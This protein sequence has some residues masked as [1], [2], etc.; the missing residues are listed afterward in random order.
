MS[1]DKMRHP[2]RILIAVV[3]AAAS[4]GWAVGALRWTDVF[5]IEDTFEASSR[6]RSTMR[7]DE[8]LIGKG[9]LWVVGGESIVRRYGI[10]RTP[11]QRLFVRIAAYNDPLI[12][13]EAALVFRSEDTLLDRSWL[14]GRRIEITDWVNTGLTEFELRVRS[15]HP[16]GSDPRPA[17]KAFGFERFGPSPPLHLA[18]FVFFFGACTFFWFLILVFVVPSAAGAFAADHRD[19]MRTHRRAWA[20]GLL[21]CISALAWLANHGAWA[22][23]KDY[24]DR[25]AI[26]NGATMLES[27]YAAEKLY[28]RSRVRPAFPALIQPLLVAFPHR[29]E[30]YWI[31]PSDGSTRYW[32]IY[33]QDDS[34]YGLFAFPAMSLMSMALAVVI[35]LV[36]Y[37]IYRRLDVDPLVALA[38]TVIS[39]FYFRGALTIAVTQTVNLL[40]NVVAVWCFLTWG[41][42][43]QPSRRFA[44]GLV[45]GYAFLVKETALTTA[46]ALGLFV[47]ID[48]S[49]IELMGRIKSSVAFWAGALVWPILY[50]AGAGGAGFVELFTNFDEHLDQQ[51]LNQFEALTPATALR[52]L[53]TVF[54]L[55]LIPALVGIS[56]AIKRKLPGP[57]PRFFLAWTIGCLPVFTLPYIFPRF[58][59]YFI[60]AFAL[61]T[62]YAFIAWRAPQKRQEQL[63]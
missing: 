13:V 45:L 59:Q 63:P 40:I 7:R 41:R 51:T 19:A 53:Y 32:Y 24:D 20:L 8:G 54:G 17:V 28:F 21:V 1:I 48:G 23:K 31:N 3:L 22:A 58:L 25:T 47:L 27:G 2:V 55:G 26:G 30:S 29:L 62:V 61:W 9:N 42:A 52:D 57:A 37:S 50:F 39:I 4:V 15:R 6:I 10:F 18:G 56:I 16:P 36:I 38:A 44:A 60:P 34:S 35:A 14:D 11:S 33:D 12:D 5:L 43:S 46:L 49:R